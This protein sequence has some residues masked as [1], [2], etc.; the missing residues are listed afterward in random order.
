MKL[1]DALEIRVTPSDQDNWVDPGFSWSIEGYTG[2]YVYI[3]L[4]FEDYRALEQDVEFDTLSITFWGTNFFQSLN[5]KEV[6]Q[7]T[8]LY[9]PLTKQ[10]DPKESE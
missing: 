5:G 9:W 8:T 6:R 3:Q 1:I 7:G 4:T 2:D 10:I